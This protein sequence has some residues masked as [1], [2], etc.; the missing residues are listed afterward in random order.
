MFKLEI[1]GGSSVSSCLFQSFRKI[2]RCHFVPTSCHFD[3]RTLNSDHHFGSSELVSSTNVLSCT[4]VR[5]AGSQVPLLWSLVASVCTVV[6]Y[7]R[8]SSVLQ[9]PPATKETWA[10][11]A[12]QAFR[13]VHLHAG[14]RLSTPSPPQ[15]P[16][17]PVSITCTH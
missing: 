3:V 5:V 14:V 1:P 11:Q 15:T 10:A 7:C 12:F 6:L 4:S 8:E 2:L 13:W 16:P 17:N 9:V